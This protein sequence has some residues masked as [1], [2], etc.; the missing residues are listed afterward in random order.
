MSSS[1]D[2]YFCVTDIKQS[3]DLVKSSIMECPLCH[4]H[5]DPSSA[6]E[7][8]KFRCSFKNDPDIE[9]YAFFYK[10]IRTRYRENYQCAMILANKFN[11]PDKYLFLNMDDKLKWKTSKY[12]GDPNHF[13][14][15]RQH[16]C[17]QTETDNPIFKRLVVIM[18]TEPD[19]DDEPQAETPK[20]ALEKQQEII[21]PSPIESNNNY[22][23]GYISEIDDY[24]DD[25]ENVLMAGHASKANKPNNVQPKQIE[26]MTIDDEDDPY[27]IIEPSL[28]TELTTP[29]P[30]PPPQEPQQEILMPTITQAMKYQM[31]QN[32]EYLELLIT[33]MRG[34]LEYGRQSTSGSVTILFQLLRF[35]N[36]DVNQFR[37]PMNVFS[38][39]TDH[40]KVMEFMESIFKSFSHAGT[41]ATKFGSLKTVYYYVTMNPKSSSGQKQRAAEIMK[42]LDSY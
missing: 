11:D 32:Y 38:I 18:T 20:L 22:T 30:P 34:Y 6:S 35:L 42:R 5:D 15:L 39:I 36:G 26:Y 27:E 40:A 4:A 31:L 7:H 24:E 2:M 41:I 23:G 1:T 28:E 12:A 21:P 37:K 9:V 8:F 19:E 10:T 14:A 17:R 13:R 16:W 29:P 33:D 25:N 3:L